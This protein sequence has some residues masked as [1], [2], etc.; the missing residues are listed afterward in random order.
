MKKSIAFIIVGV[1][2]GAG[3]TH[4]RTG[5]VAVVAKSTT[6]RFVGAT[7]AQTPLA[8][9][10]GFLVGP[11]PVSDQVRSLVRFVREQLSL[12]PQHFQCLG[13]P[14]ES[15]LTLLDSITDWVAPRSADI[16]Q[17]RFEFLSSRNDYLACEGRIFSIRQRLQLMSERGDADP[18]V[19]DRLEQEL[20]CEESQLPDL[21]AE[22]KTAIIWLESELSEV[23]NIITDNLTPEQN[24]MWT[25][26]RGNAPGGLPMAAWFVPGLSEY[27]REAL[28]NGENPDEIFTPEQKSISDATMAQYG[29]NKELVNQ[30]ELKFFFGKE[31]SHPTTV[32]NSPAGR[33]PFHAT[34]SNDAAVSSAGGD[35]TPEHGAHD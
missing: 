31:P 29:L 17:I 5:P 10:T 24:E 9:P 34:K 2:I 19:V 7:K 25:A 1:L 30:A 21:K 13:C 18:D 12:T 14:E 28:R 3:F 15:I 27:Q 23:V 26:V 20:D 35:E 22:Y 16:E 4:L 33:C 6:P 32:G 11:Y 8:R